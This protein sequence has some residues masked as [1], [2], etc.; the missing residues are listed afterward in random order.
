[1]P[2]MQMLQC[3]CPKDE[4]PASRKTAWRNETCY[5]MAMMPER[6]YFVR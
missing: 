2:G 1:M 3:T 4:L 5:V 6:P